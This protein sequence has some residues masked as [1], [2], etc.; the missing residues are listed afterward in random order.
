[1]EAEIVSRTKKKQE[2]EEL[3]R[4]G[5]ALI[6]LTVTQTVGGG[7][8]TAYS[9]ALTTVPATS[10]VGL[11][12]LDMPLL[13]YPF[14]DVIAFGADHSTIGASTFGVTSHESVAICPV[15]SPP[16]SVNPPLGRTLMLRST[17][18]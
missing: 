16:W 10:I 3:Q 13:L 14:T 8:V 4:L 18:L 1:M 7:F 9:N 17:P 12:D 6:T 5:A 11:V 2:V 15:P